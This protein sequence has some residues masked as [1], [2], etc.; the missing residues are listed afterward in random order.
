MLQPLEQRRGLGQGERKDQ[1]IGLG[2]GQR[3]LDRRGRGVPITTHL[4]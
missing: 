3:C 4:R 1:A 2:D